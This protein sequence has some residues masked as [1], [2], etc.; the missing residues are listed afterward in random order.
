KW[1]HAGRIDADK[2][3]RLKDSVPRYLMHIPFSILPAGLHRFLTDP[4]ILKDKLYF[5]F[6]R[7]FKL[8]FSQQMREQWI[9]DMLNEGKKKHILSDE[10]AAT[11]E[12]QL[13]EP[14]I[15]KYLITLVLHVL[16][17]PVTQIVSG[18]HVWIWN[19]THPEVTPTER[20]AMSLLI[21][22]LYQ[23]VP[24]S[25]GSFARGLITCSV[26]IRDRNFKDYNIALFLSFFKY[27]GYLA[28]PIQMTYRYPALARFM[29]AHWATDAVHIVPVFGER[30]ALFEHWIFCIFY[31]WPLTIRRR[32][33]RISE[34]RRTIPA[35]L[36]H[37]P[38][39]AGVA[40]GI[41]A[42]AHYGYFTKTGM[43]PVTD[44]MWYIKPLFC[45]ILLV[46]AACGWV[47]TR[48]AGGL[49]R[50]K[51]IVSAAIVGLAIGILY[52]V[53][54]YKMEQSWDMEQVQLWV[55]LIWRSFA[56]A[57]FC[58]IGAIITEIKLPDP[59]MK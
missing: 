25:P 17:L 53:T 18:I 44:N 43:A 38:L 21:L 40:V 4:Q 56:M 57:I 13:H 15:Q 20:T 33:Q 7:P 47:T 36:W 3:L 9:L 58:T 59:D 26:A 5:L 1:H 14:Y 27:I 52:S 32:M 54:A 28:F 48:F 8:Y 49:T 31:N 30:G 19:V 51:R 10:D 45:L 39:A 2:A 34:L 29:A 24:L 23:I 11:I 35:R 37:L 12:S 55:P 46:P 6:V 16:T 41:F 42:A 22:G 50:M